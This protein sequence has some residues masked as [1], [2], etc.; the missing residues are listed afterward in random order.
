MNNIYLI[1]AN[2]I[3]Q[4]SLVTDN[5]DEKFINPTIIQSQVL[6]LQPVIGTYLYDT[7]CRMVDDGVV[8]QYTSYNTLLEEYIKPYLIQKVCSELQV[9]LFAKFTNNGM[10]QNTTMQGNGIGRTDVVYLKEHYDNNAT[11][12]LNRM[13]K[14]IQANISLYPEYARIRT[15]ADMHK[16]DN[17]YN[18]HIVL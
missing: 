9:A 17:S 13:V 6:G 15:T 8:E 7:I 2:T 5:V 3:K 4:Y 12:Y 1:D 14:Y 16:D 18:T 10:R 11:F